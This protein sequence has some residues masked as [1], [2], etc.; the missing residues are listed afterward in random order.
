MYE[1]PTTNIILNDEKLEA[2]QLRLGARQGSPLSYTPFQHC[3]EGLTNEIRK[4]KQ[5]KGIP[6]G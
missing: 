5:V 4:E 3:V 6:M 1:K 2:F